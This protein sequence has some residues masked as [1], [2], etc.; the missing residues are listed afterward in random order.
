M[1]KIKINYWFALASIVTFVCLLI[2]Y[3]TYLGGVYY[4]YRILLI[5]IIPIPFWY[6]VIKKSK[7]TSNMIESDKEKDKDKNE[8]KPNKDKNAYWMWVVLAIVV[9]I[10]AISISNIYG[11]IILVPN[12]IYN[13]VRSYQGKN[14]RFWLIFAVSLI[15]VVLLYLMTLTPIFNNSED[16]NP[17]SVAITNS[18]NNAFRSSYIDECSGV[19]G[20]KTFCACSVGVLFELYPDLATNKARIDRVKS[21]GFNQ[22]ETDAIVAKCR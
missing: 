8:V 7:V 22:Y 9:S 16:P 14:T 19:S 4:F 1:S 3:T 15:A 20:D 2:L 13:A 18:Q 10:Y 17:S 12:L 5:L 6:V 21:E 11:A